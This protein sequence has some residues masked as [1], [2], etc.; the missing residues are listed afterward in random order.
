MD[1]KVQAFKDWANRM[2]GRARFREETMTPVVISSARNVGN[3]IWVTSRL[4]VE[5]ETA[6]KSYRT[7]LQEGA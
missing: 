2:S 5:D 7:V 6:S 3:C 4:H 1:P